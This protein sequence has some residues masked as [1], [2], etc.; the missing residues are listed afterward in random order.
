MFVIPVEETIPE[1]I[2]TNIVQPRKQVKV[3]DFLQKGQEKASHIVHESTLA[4]SKDENL[5]FQKEKQ[6]EKLKKTTK[7]KTSS[8]DTHLVPT[9][10]R[11]TCEKSEV[12]EKI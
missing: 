12:N 7:M 5:D 10:G 2:Q 11:P 3:T 4:G 8:A 1:T 9:R 6:L